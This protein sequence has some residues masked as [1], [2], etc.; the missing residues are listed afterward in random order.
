MQKTLCAFALGL[1]ALTSSAANAAPLNP[2]GIAQHVR[3]SLANDAKV[4]TVAD[5]PSRRM[6]QYAKPGGKFNGRRH[7]RHHRHHSRDWDG[8]RYRAYRGWNRYYDRPYRWRSR[9]CVAVGPIWF[10]P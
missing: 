10:C 7:M 4:E 1:A 5:R 8:P 6:N 3:A 9:G 2:A